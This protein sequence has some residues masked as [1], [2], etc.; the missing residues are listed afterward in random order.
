MATSPTVVTGASS[1]AVRSYAEAVCLTAEMRFTSQDNVALVD[2]LLD[3]GRNWLAVSH[4]HFDRQKFSD[5]P[6]LFDLA[7]LELDK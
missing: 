3:A 2:A 6:F 5:P 4:C 7:R 1:V